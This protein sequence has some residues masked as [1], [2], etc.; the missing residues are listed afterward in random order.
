MDVWELTT[1]E[2]GT[3]LTIVKAAASDSAA[4]LP[5]EVNGVSVTEIGSHAFS[6]GCGAIE[7]LTLPRTVTRLGDYAFFGCRSLRKLR[8]HDS[9]EYW[10]GGE[11]ANCRDL[12]SLDLIM[13]GPRFGPSLSAFAQELSAELEITVRYTDGRLAK[14]I[15][16]EYF[17]F[18]EERSGN[19]QVFFN[20]EIQGV[21]YTYHHC[22][23]KRQL[24]F[25][26]YDKL[27]PDLLR[28][29]YDVRAALRLALT[30]LRWPEGL[31]AD[32]AGNYTEF[33]R[34]HA[35]EAVLALTEASD[36]EGLAFALR[37]TAPLPPEALAP[38][39][40]LAR[41]Q[42]KTEA[43]ALLLQFSKGSS[44]GY[45]KTFDL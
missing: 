2:N 4:V 25:K 38:A 8:I 41:T 1:A 34:K 21:G 20:Y 42:K 18:S 40:E 37:L 15:L 3:G 26:I 44:A 22:F 6:E 30:R 24:N 29:S 5:D 35:G 33:V 16:P 31:S 43:T 19:H 45:D 36:S 9:I 10:G 28:R 39:L 12:R 13:C 27:W 32:A 14:I 23:E 7:E 17:E 11:F